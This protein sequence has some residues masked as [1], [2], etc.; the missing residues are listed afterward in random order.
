MPAISISPDQVTQRGLTLVELLVTLA[1]LSSVIVGSG[2][3]FRS[4]APRWSLDQAKVQLLADLKRARINA[5][6]KETDLFLVPTRSGYKIVGLGT[7]RHWP[8]RIEATWPDHDPETG[9]PLK[10]FPVEENVSFSI[11]TGTQNTTITVERMTGR[12][13]VAS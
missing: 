3:A 1:I 13:Y 5:R 6:G 4:V 8:R 11:S 9:I 2:I 7:E 12:I 10:T